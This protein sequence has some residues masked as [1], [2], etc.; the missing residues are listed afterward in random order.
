[1]SDGAVKVDFKKT[2]KLFWQPPAG[3][4]SVVEVPPLQF[5]MID[6]AGDPNTAPAYAKAIECCAGR[7]GAAHRFRKPHR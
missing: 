3:R 6:G 7:R 5:A 2:M 1:M 4:F